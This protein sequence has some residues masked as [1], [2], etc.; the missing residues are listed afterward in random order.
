MVGFIEGGPSVA[1]QKAPMG[2]VQLQLFTVGR[3][4]GCRHNPGQPEKLQS[5]LE[6]KVMER[7]DPTK[8]S[9]ELLVDQ[10]EGHKKD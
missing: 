1:S 3:D 7:E 6:P 4:C 5:T 8:Y 2:D 9:K 10:R